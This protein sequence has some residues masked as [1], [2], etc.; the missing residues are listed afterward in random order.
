MFGM[1]F[2][3]EKA[4]LTTSIHVYIL[5][6]INA[7]RC[8]PAFLPSRSAPSAYIGSNPKHDALS[9]TPHPVDIHAKLYYTHSWGIIRIIHPDAHQNREQKTTPR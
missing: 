3:G 7:I 4:I 2:S 8:L 5:P 6:N 1:S 9:G